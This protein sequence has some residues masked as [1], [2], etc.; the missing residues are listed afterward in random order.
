MSIFLYLVIFNLAFSAEKPGTANKEL[1]TCTGGKGDLSDLDP[2][3]PIPV[4]QY[5]PCET[6]ISQNHKVSV[7]AYGVLSHSCS[8]GSEVVRYLVHDNQ[9]DPEYSKACALT[10]SYSKCLSEISDTGSCSGAKWK[11]IVENKVILVSN[12]DKKSCFNKAKLMAAKLL[13]KGF[14]CSESGVN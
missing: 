3:T 9:T 14:A 5:Q 12:S 7:K 10:Y 11:K 6:F 4:A 13:S 2:K 8:I 1:Y